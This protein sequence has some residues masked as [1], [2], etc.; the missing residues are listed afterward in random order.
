MCI[1]FL[2]LDKCK[3]GEESILAIVDHFTR[4][5]RAYATTTKSGKT[6]KNLIFNDNALKFGFPCRIHRDQGGEY[7]NQF[8]TQLKKLSG[9]AG[10]RTT[11]YHPM[12]NGQ[13]ER[14]NRTFLQML[15]TLTEKTKVKLVGI[16][17]QADL[18]V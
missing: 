17:Q 14:M 6:A 7:E 2:H 9:L 3:G 11:P 13:V 16:N 15:K 8:F 5:A 4:F 12:G 18:W 10:S 1:D